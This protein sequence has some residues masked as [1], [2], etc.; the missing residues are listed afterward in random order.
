[1]VAQY[2]MYLT[3]K[4]IKG[5]KYNMFAKEAEQKYIL[6]NEAFAAGD[7][8]LLKMVVTDPMFASMN[9]QL[10]NM[11]RKGQFVWQSHGSAEPPR[12]LN[13]TYAKALMEHNVEHKVV[14]ITVR[15]NVKQSA[16]IY[17]GSKLVGGNPDDIKSIAEYIV[18]EKWLTR[19]VEDDWKIAG[20]INPP[21]SQ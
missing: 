15:V 20:K 6:M 4:A 12:S 3:K 16:A 13:L 14:Q 18:L 8:D 5:W 21:A 9:A 2:S 19:D 10:K 1:M 7:K 17:Q 11:T